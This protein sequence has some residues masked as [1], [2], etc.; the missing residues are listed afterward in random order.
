MPRLEAGTVLM[1]VSSAAVIALADGTAM[2]TGYWAGEFL[3]PYQALTGAGHRVVVATPGG[4]MPTPDPVSLGA[5][6]A[7]VRA[8]LSA[9]PEL[10]A[11]WRLE[12]IDPAGMRALV[13]PGGYAPMVDLAVSPAL[14]PRRRP[15]DRRYLPCPGGAAG[16]PRAGSA[17]VLRGLQ[18]GGVHRR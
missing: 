5:E 8:R 9:I 15:S 3:L 10:Q 7:G 11:P 6:P 2:P 13:L 17:L 14:G 18:D 12:D 16:G 1:V 4:L